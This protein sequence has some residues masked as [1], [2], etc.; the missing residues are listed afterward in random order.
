MAADNGHL[1]TLKWIR[2]NG[3]DWDKWAA[4]LAASNGHLET[5]KWIHSVNGPFDIENLRT[6]G[7]HRPHIIEWLDTLN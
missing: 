1:E 4:N 6:T 2:A 5:L 3:G 7:R